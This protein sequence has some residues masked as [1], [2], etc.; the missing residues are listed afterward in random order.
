MQDRQQ[1]RRDLSPTQ[2][3]SLALG[4][5]IGFGCFVLPGDFLD[6]SGPMGAT[7]GIILGGVVMII[8]A[9]AYGVMVRNFVVAGAEFAYAYCAFGRYHAYICGWFWHWV[10]SA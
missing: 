3:G 7:I 4:C 10:I 1:L 8:I 9:R 2:V 5:I 6:R